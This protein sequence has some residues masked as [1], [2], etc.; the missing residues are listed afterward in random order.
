MKKKI[1]LF[2]TALS[3][4]TLASCG[5]DN[6]SNKKYRGAVDN[7][8]GDVEIPDGLRDDENAE[9]GYT[10][11][12]LLENSNGEYDIVDVQELSGEPGTKTKASSNDYTGYTA[13]AFEQKDIAEDGSTVIEI[14]YKAIKYVL[15]FDDIQAERGIL[16][17]NG[18]YY[19]YQNKA[20]LVAK[21]N[22]GYK[23]KGWYSGDTLLSE[24]KTY[25]FSV[26]EDLNIVGEFEIIPEFSYFTFESDQSSC[27]ITGRVKG[28]PLNLVIPEGVTKIGENSFSYSSISSIVL[29]SSLTEINS[30]A[31]NNSNLLSVTVNSN[32]S[33]VS[34]AFKNCSRL[35][36]I[37]NNSDM[38]L[39]I[40]SNSYGYIGKY[41]KV[42]HQSKD[43]PSIFVSS[44]DFLFVVLNDD[45]VLV[46]YTG[47][48]NDVVLPSSVAVGDE[49]YTS[50]TVGESALKGNENLQVLTIPDAVTEIGNNA[51]SGCE[52]LLEVYNLSDDFDVYTGSSSN[53][54]VGEY[55]KVIHT[56]IDEPR[57]VFRTN[58]M[59]YYLEGDGSNTHAYI[60]S[61]TPD[62]KDVV[63]NQIENYPTGLDREL[64]STNEIIETVTL[65]EGVQYIGQYAF[66]KCINLKSIVAN[67]VQYIDSYAFQSCSSLTD[68]SIN[69]CVNLNDCA[70]YYCYKLNNINMP[71]IT[72]IG[73]RAFQDCYSLITITLPETLESI[74]SS[75]F[76]EC[77]KLYQVINKSSLSISYDD[78]GN[79]YVG[80]YAKDITDVE[81]DFYTNTNGY[82]TYLDG[83]DKH[84]IAYMGD[85][86]ELVIPTDVYEIDRGALAYG[87]YTSISV[88][89]DTILND[90]VFYCCKNLEYLDI[91]CY[92][93]DLYYLFKPLSNGLVNVPSTLKTLR[94]SGYRSYPDSYYF[95]YFQNV[96]SLVLACTFDGSYQLYDKLTNLKNVYFDGTIEDWCELSFSNDYDNPMYKASNF[97][98]R[99]TN[100]NV[101]IG[102]NKYSLL[103]ELI[104][105]ETVTTLGSY[106]FY[107]FNIKKVVIPNNV[108]SY[109]DAI[110][111]NCSNLT[112]VVFSNTSSI[113][114]R[115]F[116]NCSNL[117]EFDIPSTVEEID[118]YAFANCTGL[119]KIN[120]SNTLQEIQTGAFMG[121]SSLIKV[122]IPESIT[123]LSDY[124]FSNCYSLQKVE[125]AGNV[126]TIGERVFQNCFT[127]N[128]M[129]LPASVTQIGEAAFRNCE[130]MKAFTFKE[131][132]ITEIAPYLFAGCRRLTTVEFSDNITE[133]GDH[134]FDNCNKIGLTKYEGGLYF[135]SESEPYKWLIKVDKDI[136]KVVVNETC[137]IILGSAFSAS[138]KIESIT[139]PNTI[140]KLGSIFAGLNSLKYL[141][142]P[143]LGDGENYQTL[144]YFFGSTS[145][146]SNWAPSTLK[147]V[148]INGNIT[149]IP[150]HAFNNNNYV[151]SITIPDTVTSIGNNAFS[152]TGISSFDL[153]NV[154][155]VGASAFANCKNLNSIDFGK[156]TSISNKMFENCTSLVNVSIPSTIT[157]IGQYAFSNT[158][159]TS[160]DLSTLS[161]DTVINDHAFNGC[162]ELVEAT[163]PNI[164][165][166]YSYL[167]LDCEKLEN[168][169]IPST[170]EEIQTEAFNNTRLK[171]VTIPAGISTTIGSLAFGNN[172]NLET[173][174]INCTT[175]A[176]GTTYS[177]FLGGSNKIKNVIFG[178]GCTIA[179]A[180]LFEGKSSITSVTFP[181]TL[182]EIG[183][184]AF[185]GCS[186]LTT[187]TIPE[188]VTSIGDSAFNG[189]TKL[190]EVY[191]KSNLTLELG[192]TSNGYVAYYAL[193]V[194]NNMNDDSIYE[195]DAN[196]FTFI[197][198]GGKGYLF[199]Y[200]GEES[201]IT[202]PE[203]FT[204]NNVTYNNYDIYSS[205]FAYN[206][207]IK[208]V[209]IPG[210]VKTIGVSAFK[211]CENLEDV[212]L[213]E[214]V[215]YIE[216]Q[217]FYDCNALKNLSLPN[218]LEAIN[219]T[220]SYK[221]YSNLNYYL[222]SNGDKYLGNEN[223]HY[224]VFVGVRSG[225]YIYSINVEDG[226]KIIAPYAANYNVNTNVS[227]TLPEGLKYIGDYAFADCTKTTSSITFPTTLEYIGN[228]AFDNSG[229]MPS[230]LL[231]NTNVKYIGT[232]AF[233]A[234]STSNKHAT[235]TL[236]ESLIELGSYAF[237]YSKITEIKI[238]KNVKIIDD[239]VFYECSNLVTI[240][241]ASKGTELGSWLFYND[242]ITKVYYDGTMDDWVTLSFAGGQYA[243]PIFEGANLYILD[244][245]G[246]VS[247]NGNTYSV[248]EE[249]VLTD[250]SAEI[251]SCAFYNSKVE[252]IT[253][254]ASI[255]KIG[256]N[257]FSNCS[258]L[259]N[260]YYD[261]TIDDW[262][263]IS[264]AG[265]T[266][267]PM[268]YA[269]NFF[270]L[271]DSGTILH[272]GKKY[273]RVTEVTITSDI[274]KLSDYAFYG[275]KDLVV[276]NLSNTIKEIGKYA[277][278]NCRIKNITLPTNL[279]KIGSYAFANCINLSS[280]DLPN[281]VNEIDSYA[282]S[283]CRSL[284]E[285]TLPDTLRV[286]ESYA[287]NECYN[288]VNVTIPSSVTKFNDSAFIKC[289]SLQNVY[290]D[291]TISDWCNLEITKEDSTPM[292]YANN[293][294]L[295]DTNDNIYKLLTDLTTPSGLTTIK[296]YTFYG[297][298]CLNYL[299]ISD[300]VTTIS[301]Y[302]FTSCEHLYIAYLGKNVATIG[303]SAFSY[304]YRLIEVHYYSTLKLPAWGK[305]GYGDI[306]LYAV[307]DYTGTYYNSHSFDLDE[308]GHIK[309]I[310]GYIFIDAF[311]NYGFLVDY[312]GDETDLV[313]PS[314]FTIGTNTITRYGIKQYAFYKND[315][316]TSVVIPNNCLSNYNLNGT[317]YRAFGNYAFEYCKN[318]ASV[319]LPN[320]LASGSFADNVFNYCYKLFEVYN[321]STDLSL[322]TGSSY[323]G[324]Y[325]SYY[326]KVIHTSLDEDSI[327]TKDSN[328][329]MYMY[330]DSKYYL[331]GYAG[332]EKE[333]TLPASF[334]FNGNTITEYEIYNSAFKEYDTIR[335]GNLRSIIIS[336]SVTAIRDSAFSNCSA[337]MNVVIPESV[338]SFG[339]NIFFRCNSL[340]S[341]MIPDSIESINSQLFYCVENLDSVIIPDSVTSI[342]YR[343]FYLSSNLSSIYFEGTEEQWYQISIN[344][345]SNLSAKTVV[346]FYSE[347]EPTD[348]NTEIHYWH[349]VNGIP[350]IWE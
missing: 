303:S 11:K 269:K 59:V 199:G 348:T 119:K 102:G 247:Y 252:N 301:S 19:A 140:T 54:S 245:D 296:A 309:D 343:S 37:Y 198:K 75:A 256:A 229:G 145:T 16:S 340:I 324:S 157:T 14:K 310:N 257:A 88:N 346:Y 21:P 334:E 169:E 222:S 188:N 87:D 232:F 262:I 67:D 142:V 337:L 112:E 129:I 331:I 36:E 120:L 184:N 221:G 311:T 123:V 115:M 41:A 9:G 314:S 282:F 237:S 83:S 216:D 316:I 213:E 113:A 149:S 7:T 146:T 275:F 154:E 150:A 319:T 144:N 194:H 322:S 186:S 92:S 350:T 85:S 176:Y 118:S 166:I 97:Y 210:S 205:A 218:S 227:I 32:L 125:F 22:I 29:P 223:N 104:I 20:T 238:P 285:V 56:S 206:N 197:V 90:S 306:K 208:S 134:A 202:L 204:K 30:F 330:L 271:N 137:Q 141:E 253:I 116:E 181:S 151:T 25:S 168:C 24:D 131:L 265:N 70:F 283:F 274:E 127:V 15:T 225:N 333:I 153:K 26:E 190:L 81:D 53:G 99:D 217:A 109:G 272:N 200:D 302:A 242:K 23:F 128:D 163:L 40:G 234:S 211:G 124:L 72:S 6:A 321:L 183:K 308:N 61:Y 284:L 68:V 107:G 248:V 39:E 165:T 48:D 178:E 5:N 148:K 196:G 100:G 335:T 327:I 260:V 304:C 105:P 94:L 130:T 126:E 251:G 259:T 292:Y 180:E 219:G 170:V 288:L 267:N 246:E 347:D 103:D 187:I 291:G 326:A 93:N 289:W 167:F 264:F 43:E 1:V 258:S 139:I 300:D 345:N 66:N 111:S 336:D 156:I 110:F 235:I 236:P 328:G 50:Y 241:I 4:F 42:I 320:N 57:R 98:V 279:T 212:T 95:D 189:C 164:K 28:A 69:K 80:Y 47:D 338:T 133:V 82:I 31:F 34:N 27:T 158:G 250:D 77:Y 78:Y 281:T 12:H 203:S 342:G 114:S 239:R 147:T 177:S 182:T 45:P 63:I 209:I 101:E 108:T 17:G 44:N 294:Y 293:F 278:Y 287:F 79:G 231:D 317:F 13:L 2:L 325:V 323:P 86:T 263:E 152:N 266:S 74:G 313:L 249:I 46:A 280:I 52:N 185:W 228:H 138:D 192:E 268:T 38:E 298:N 312:I 305:S 195:K 35:F 179:F 160:I 172:S 339:E 240:E 207:V 233:Y 89:D 51:F 261:G 224:L 244:V 91:P 122:T 121:C 10:V 76:Y 175:S 161:N 136:T 18:E 143:F 270:I 173:V 106:Q 64:F 8:I 341:I 344:A 307:G 3:A 220:S 290:Y 215:L 96:E 58:N 71:K 329:F 277:F 243:N 162:K 33:I 286:V 84:L 174:T 297:F 332:D 60:I 255:K 117:V 315:K 193:A 159:L 135:G 299:T 214:G 62:G 230:I 226:C 295:L 55:A 132:G 171:T 49:T 273:S 276:I 155:T 254:P 191:N 201:S 65:G 318:L 73:S 349:Y